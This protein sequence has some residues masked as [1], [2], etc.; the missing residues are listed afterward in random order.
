MQCKKILTPSVSLKYDGIFF[1][2]YAKKFLRSTSLLKGKK[3]A[4]RNKFFTLRVTELKGCTSCRTKFTK[5][6]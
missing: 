5:Y 1:L 6:K 2:F 4:R 3:N